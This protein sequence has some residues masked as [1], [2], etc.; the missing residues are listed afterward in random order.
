MTVAEWT[1]RA[2][3]RVVRA[4]AGRPVV[5]VATALVLAAA[6]LAY[7]GHALGF[8][9]SHFRLLPQQARYV[10]S[11]RDALR[12]FGELNDIIVVVE[13]AHPAEARGYAA[14]LV[15]ALGAG[16]GLGASRVVYRVDPALFRDRGLLYL[17][18]DDL[19]RLR[20]RVQDS[21]ELVEGYAA[22]PSLDR[23]LAGLNQ[24]LAGAML[25]GFFDIGLQG[26][27]AADV[28][29]LRAITD[30]IA[31]RLDGRPQYSSPWGAAFSL[32]RLDDGEAG[33]FLSAD[34]RLLFIFVERQRR[35]GDFAD[36]RE[37]VTA[38]R[39]AIAALR[40]E[41]PGVRAGVTGAPAISNDEMASAFASSKVATALALAA[42]LVLLI[43]AFRRVGRALVLLAV[44]VTSLCWSMG[45]VTLGVGHLSIFSVMF[46]SIVVGIGI[47]YGIYFVYRYE[48]EAASASPAPALARAAERSGPGMLLGA[49]TA[50][51]TFYALML[52]DFQGIREFGFVSGTAVVAAFVS[53]ITLL[54]AVLVLTDG[55]RRPDP[56]AAA[57][58]APV[59]E[60]R[61]LARLTA[62][63]GPILVGA[64]VLTALAAVSA[65]GVAFD[66]NLLNLQARGVESVLWEER[67][68]RQTGRSGF[69]ALASAG[70][71]EE[72]QAKHAAFAALPSVSRVESVLQVL[73]DRQPDK[74]RLIG[75]IA[76]EV[77]G[78]VVAA[79]PASPAVGRVRAELEVLRRR[80]RIAA[81]RAPEAARADLGALLASIDVALPRL[82]GSPDGAAAALEPFQRA[83]RDD[84]AEKLGALQRSVD[85]PPVTIEELPAELRHRYVGRSGRF[86][87]RI[88]PAVDIW[89]QA[90]AERFVRELRAVDADVTGP[91]VTSY[92]A[93]GYIRR[94]Y[95]EGTIYALAVV[96]LVTFAVL[97][98][99]RST[100]LALTPLGLG[101]VW[102]LGVMRLMGLPFN[103]ANVWAL[104]LVIGTAA[105]FGLNIFVRYAQG[106]EAGEPPLARSTVL[107]VVLSG[108]TTIGG[109]G[110]LMV[111]DHRGIWSLGLLLTVGVTASLLASL[112][113]LP[114]LMTLFEPSGRSLGEDE[115]RA[116]QAAAP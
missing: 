89:Q 87:L 100:L 110:S 31:G 46:I 116:R 9:T 95:F 48:E 11:L 53:M 60:A 70:T 50:A 71:L 103:L 19:T 3:A 73:P 17:S 38:L 92:E 15:Q 65:S 66:Y 79:A 78:V 40:G 67:I 56:R 107:A 5:T 112:V 102:T 23:L 84:F 7:T 54:P 24:Q 51:G 34:R 52:T 104:P 16:G 20:D 25:R 2:V 41:F 69:A 108:L 32:G 59:Q 81:E 14:R 99:L 42:T 113:V 72:L 93:I 74:R 28:R 39:S 68:L 26:G 82:A 114:A 29:F 101:V 45:L 88:H 111:A 77:D 58:G 106:L 22:H 43:A 13:A 75:Q 47:D 35:E 91:P 10:V 63:P 30:Q 33:Y 80:L 37:K 109:F 96:G 36:D 97:R 57:R 62:R 90:G 55:R 6:A 44:L 49:L 18:V 98:R 83:L 105:E 27:S 94:G 85:P 1:G 86:L 21:R 61:W 115:A 8:V 64:A 4:C 76:P 12:E